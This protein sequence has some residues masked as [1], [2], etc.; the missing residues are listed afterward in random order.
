MLGRRPQCHILQDEFLRV[1]RALHLLC[2][3]HRFGV[4]ASSYEKDHLPRFETREHFIDSSWPDETDGPW[5]CQLR[6]Q[7][8]HGCLAF[9]LMCG[10][11]P[12][13]SEDRKQ[14]KAKIRKGLCRESLPACCADFILSLVQQDPKDRLAMRPGGIANVKN[15]NWFSKVDWGLMRQ[16]KQQA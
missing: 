16:V 12:F 8:L 15:H 2:C 14:L 5:R 6:T 11:A 1:R 4:G 13:E 9:E 3:G 10:H 7:W